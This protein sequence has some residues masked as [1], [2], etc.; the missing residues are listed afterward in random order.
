MSPLATGVMMEVQLA[1][2]VSVTTIPAVTGMKQ[3]VALEH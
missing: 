2:P 1:P 3:T